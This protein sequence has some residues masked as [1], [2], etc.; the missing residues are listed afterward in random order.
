MHRTH[1]IYKQ[2][3][4]TVVPIILACAGL[5]SCSGNAH[6]NS[7]QSIL[8]D[9]V[10]SLYVTP[11]WQDSVQQNIEQNYTLLVP[12]NNAAL[13]KQIQAIV[14]GST[15]ANLDAH[16]LLDTLASLRR[17]N[18]SLDTLNNGEVPVKEFIESS[19]HYQDTRLV[20]MVL[21]CD[22]M[23]KDGK[24]LSFRKLFNLLLP[25]GTLLSESNIFTG[26]YEAEL[27]DLFVTSL[28]EPEDQKVYNEDKVFANNNFMVDNKGITYCFENTL[29]Q[30]HSE[31]Y[32]EVFI[33]WHQLQ[34]ILLPNSPVSHLYNFNK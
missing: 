26:G 31:K 29:L 17:Q 1:T 19:I 24:M 14:G 3:I 12:K 22:I 23:Y 15:F 5:L 2:L 9:T 6:K 27:Q 7:K 8:W 10:R 13:A 28:H 30:P 32:V 11:L 20:S 34:N 25:Q 4:N 21:D 16:K 33:P 18:F